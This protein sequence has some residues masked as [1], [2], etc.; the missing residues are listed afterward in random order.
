MDFYSLP[1]I[2][3]GSS[4]T[5]LLDQGVYLK[6]CNSNNTDL[7]LLTLN[8][9]LS[10][11]STSDFNSS[12]PSASALNYLNSTF[13]T[14]FPVD[15]VFVLPIS[16]SN[17]MKYISNTYSSLNGIYY[18]NYA[19]S[20]YNSLYYKYSIVSGSSEGSTDLTGLTNAIYSLGAVI[21]VVCFFSV[22]YKMFIRLRG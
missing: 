7:G 13:N 15:S 16:T 3:V 14:S 6:I 8:Y 20:N 10:C 12:F 1:L 4:N 22:I 21:I 19:N 18:F 5:F 2:P 17:S 11:G 9:N